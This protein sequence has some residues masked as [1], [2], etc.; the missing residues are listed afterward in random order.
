MKANVIRKLKR[1]ERDCHTDLC[2]S[3]LTT[4][5]TGGR[6]AVTV[7]PHRLR[8]FVKVVR[9]LLNRDVPF[10]ILGNGSNVLASDDYFDGVVVCTRCFSHLCTFGRTVRAFSGTSASK[11]FAVCKQKGLG[12]GEFLSCL[13][14][15]IGGAVTMNAGCF[16]SQMSKV[17]K[18]VT[19]L[20]EFGKIQH[21]SNKRCNFAYRQS[22]FQRGFAVLSVTMRFTRST[23]QA[24]T[25]LA[26]EMRAKKS[27]TQPLEHRSAGS[28]FYSEKVP[29][30]LLIDRLGLKG[31]TVGGACISKKHA[32]FVLNIDKATSKDIYLIIH[33]VRARLRESCGV[34]V[35]T[36]VKLINF[37]GVTNDV[38]TKCQNRGAK[39][40]QKH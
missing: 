32:G 28:V 19:A 16:G 31:Y 11:I 1:L 17:V 7:F 10:V 13:P 3:D 21:F 2:F 35:K 26:S 20:D 25:K 37:D 14:A 9:L 29:A 15:T 24:V 36:E 6:I 8:T 27:A 23:P 18:R 22:V 34:D 5:G 30:S 33:H 40:H 39:K 38:F 4:F 12:G